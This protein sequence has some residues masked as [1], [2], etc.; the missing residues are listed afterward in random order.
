MARGLVA[1]AFLAGYVILEWVSFIHDYKGIPVTPWNPGLGV[2]FALMIVAGARYALVLFAGA[3]SAEVIVLRSD[4]DWPIVIG[5]A[6]AIATA[7]GGAAY[8]ARRWFLLD[9]GLSRLRDIVVVLLTGCAGAVL[10][11]VSLSLLLIADERL[12]LADAM[13]ASAPLLVGDVIGIAVGTPLTLRFLLH[14]RDEARALAAHFPSFVT[15]AAAVLGL[16]WL[17]LGTGKGAGGAHLF[18][19]LFLPAVVAAVRHGFDGACIG[20]AT[21]QLA[22]VG[23]LHAHGYDAAE[24]TEFQMLMLVLTATAL[25]VGIVVSERQQADIATQRMAAQLQEKTADAAVAARH[26]LV[27]GMASAVAHEINQPMTAAR[28]LARS[29]QQIITLPQ[30]DLK[31]AETNLAR[32]IEQIDHVGA[33]VRRMRELLRRGR[34]HLS[35]TDIAETLGDAIMLAKADS[36]IAQVRI[37][38][39]NSGALPLIHTDAVQIQQVVLNLVRNATDALNGAGTADPEIRVTTRLIDDPARVEVCVIDNGPGIAPEQS[40][41]LFEPLASSKREGLGLG[42]SISKSIIETHGGALWLE[43]TRPGATEFRFTLPLDNPQAA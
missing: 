4:L 6:A 28:A 36:A 27:S 40:D 9:P 32:L 24:F 13:V 5:I 2:M 7:Y 39:D 21:I 8:A 26:N 30:P 42:L 33:V 20:L 18:Y 25:V 16:L 11:A 3:V 17:I 12:D 43:S 19:L 34:P 23:V 37:A 38:L 1:A 10:S 41:R 22:L 31:R 15:F 35:T 29:A 14:P